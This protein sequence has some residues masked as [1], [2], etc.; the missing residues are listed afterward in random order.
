MQRI[1][2]LFNCFVIGGWLCIHSMAQTSHLVPQPNLNDSSGLGLKLRATLVGHNSQVFKVVFSPGGE[3]V[4]TADNDVTRVWTTTGQLLSTLQGAEPLFSPDG[5]L[6]LTTRKKRADLWDAVTG[7]LKLTLNGHDRKITATCFSPDGKKVA[8]GSEDGTVKL[9]DTATGH[10]SASLTVWR[11]KR[12]P[13]FRIVSRTFQFPLGVFVKFSPDGRTVL[14]NTNLNEE[15]SPAQLWDVTSGRLQAEFGGHTMVV[16]HEKLVF[17]DKRVPVAVTHTSFSPDGKFIATGSSGIIKLWETATGRSIREFDGWFQHMAFSPDSKWFGLIRFGT[18]V[19]LLNLETFKLQTTSGVDTAFLNQFGFSPDSEMYVTGSGFKK[20]YATLIDVS[21]GQ[22]RSKIP[23]VAKFGSD[24][25]S[26]YQKDVDVLSFHP[27]GKFL[28]GANHT[29]VRIWDVSNGRMVWETAA[30]RDPAIFDN[31]GK[32]LV[33]V[34]RDKKSV[35][36]WEMV[37]NLTSS[38]ALHKK[39]VS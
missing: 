7:K 29:S 33:M 15:D 27:S 6:L 34:G 14:T 3:L 22:V 31:G 25:V 16:P 32:L 35:L 26:D 17:V 13:R 8:T 39:Y 21:S 1:T 5:R 2:V 20:Y 9:W 24:F 18:D 38:R 4:A 30:G 28:M 36:L 11:V 12:I 23:L 10:A 37:S 19:G